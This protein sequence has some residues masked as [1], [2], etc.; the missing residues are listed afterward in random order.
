MLEEDGSHDPS[1]YIREDDNRSLAEVEDWRLDLQQCF[2]FEDEDWYLVQRQVE[3]WNLNLK[4][5]H[6][7]SLQDYEYSFKLQRGLCHGH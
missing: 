4:Q 2:R 1:D 3:D 7:Q 5:L 6:S